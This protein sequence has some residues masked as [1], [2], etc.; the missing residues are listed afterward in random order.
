V[1]GRAK[2]GST[3]AER[4]KRKP[5]AI[6]WVIEYVNLESESVHNGTDLRLPRIY[7]GVG[8]MFSWRQE[9]IR[10]ARGNGIAD[11]LAL[12]SK[13]IKTCLDYSLQF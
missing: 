10:K 11:V 9:G 8:A 13:E 12:G 4:T 1:L 6:A 2:S 3:F 7:Y 5:S